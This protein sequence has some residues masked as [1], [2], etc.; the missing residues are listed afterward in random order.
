MKCLKDRHVI[1]ELCK[2][3]RAGK[4]RGAR[5]DHCNAVAVFL[6]DHGCR[7]RMLVVPIG[8]E[9]F[10]SA[11]AD[12]LALDAADAVFFT[13]IFLRTYSAADCGKA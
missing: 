5:A 6:C 7:I 8:D 2:V 11:D 13:L 12:R 3:A 10:K 9:A 1:A 4:S